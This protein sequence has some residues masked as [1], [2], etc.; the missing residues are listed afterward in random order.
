MLVD[1]VSAASDK[2]TVGDG[3]VEPYIPAASVYSG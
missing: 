2:G 1:I 3:A